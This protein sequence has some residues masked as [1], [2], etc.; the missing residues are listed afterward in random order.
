MNRAYPGTG[1]VLTL[2]TGNR[3]RLIQLGSDNLD[4]GPLGVDLAKARKGADQFTHPAMAA[5][6][7]EGPVISRVNDLLHGIS[8]P[9]SRKH[10][11]R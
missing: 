10:A 8:F 4:F 6:F 9:L 7:I 1:R 3:H 11:T 5:Y 2:Q